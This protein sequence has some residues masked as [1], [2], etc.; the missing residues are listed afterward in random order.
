MKLESLNLCMSTRYILFCW[1]CCCC[2]FCYLCFV[3]V[4]RYSESFSCFFYVSSSST[5]LLGISALSVFVFVML[6]IRFQVS[7]FMILTD[8]FFCVIFG[9]FCAFWKALIYQQQL[10]NFQLLTFFQTKYMT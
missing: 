4:S 1:C 10:S 9:S 2:C 6:C 7:F 3:L 5:F 8:S